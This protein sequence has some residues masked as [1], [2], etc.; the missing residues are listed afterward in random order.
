MNGRGIGGDAY[1]V[2]ALV[3][4]GVDEALPARVGFPAFYSLHA[5]HPAGDGDVSVD[6]HFQGFG[7]DLLLLRIAGF[8]AGEEF[9]LGLN[10]AVVID[11][12]NGVVEDGV[13]SLV[14]Y[15]LTN[16]TRRS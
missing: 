16:G 6:V 5:Q 3:Q 4:P 13:E 2:L 8:Y 11:Q 14:P 10:A 15:F 1:P 7:C 12:N 9:F